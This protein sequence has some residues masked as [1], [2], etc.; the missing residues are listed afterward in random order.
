M[1][2]AAWQR[3]RPG[4]PRG[5]TAADLRHMASRAR[6]FAREIIFDEQARSRLTEFA[7]ELD[8]KATA[9]E[10]APQVV[11]HD[12]AAA[13]QRSDPDIGPT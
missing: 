7:A 1:S 5:E 13:A 3:S 11:S 12:E 2:N 4:Q 10:T 8:A 9:L 6:K